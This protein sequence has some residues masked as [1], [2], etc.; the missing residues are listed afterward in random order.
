MALAA[1]A[2]P[3][4]ATTFVPMS[5]A[6]LVAQAALVVEARV[7]SA[8]P[9]PV[10]GRPAT[11]YAVEVLRTLK[12]A[13]PT[14]PLTV[15]V[16]GGRGSDG[17]VYRV[18]G[19][20]V[21]VPGERTILFL[22]E[23]GDGTLGILQL[24]LGVFHEE[25]RDGRPLA[26]RDLS[27][28]RPVALDGRAAEAEPRGRARDFGAFADWLAARGS[29]E[30]GP[31]RYLVEVAPGE[32][33]RLSPRY[34]LLES[35]GRPFRWFDGGGSWFAHEAGQAG[36]PGGGFAEFQAALAAWNAD[37]GSALGLAYGG[38]TSRSSGFQATDGTS[39]ILFDD[40]N[41]EITG[42]FGCGSG[43]VLAIGGFSRIS[44]TGVHGGE[45]FWAIDE[46]EIV[47]QDGAGCFFA[48]NGGKNGEVV[49]THELGHALG[50]GHSCG[51]GASPSCGDP[52]LNDAIMR[53]YAHGDGRGA[54]LGADDQRAVA[55]LYGSGPAPEPPP[56]PPPPPPP[57]PPPPPP[58]P[59]P[60]PPPPPPP[61]PPPPPP[62]P[63]PGLPPA[64]ADL[65]GSA[66]S[67]TAATLTW[68]DRSGGTAST[69]VEVRTGAAFQQAR[70]LPPGTTATTFDRLEPGTRYLF[71]VRARNA[72]GFSAYSNQVA[73]TPEEPEPEEPPPAAPGTL[74]AA[75]VACDAGR[76]AGLLDRLALAAPASG[77]G[78]G[79][80]L[81]LTGS[82]DFA[83][84][85]YGVEP[86][87]GLE[88]HLAFSTNPEETTLLRNPERPQ[89]ASVSLTRNHLASDLVAP[90]DTGELRLTVDPGLNPGAS[91]A[92]GLLAIDNLAGSA[93]GATSAR[94]GRG[95]SALV[96][97]CH[98]G[99]S[100]DDV[101]LFRVLAKIVRARVEGAKSYEVAI[102]RAPAPG[103]YRL[104]VYPQRGNGAPLGRLA[105]EVRVERDARGALAGGTLAIL[106][107]CGAGE[108]A[109]CSTVTAYSEL[110]LRPPA[111][112]GGAA[113]DL[114]AVF[115]P[116]GAAANGEVAV[117][118]RALLAGSTWERP[119]GGAE[120][121][122]ARAGGAPGQQPA[123]LAAAD[124]R[125]D[126]ERLAGF[127]ER[128]GLE[129]PP[130]AAPGV[131]LS[132]TRTGD[133]AG[134]AYR[135]DAPGA[136]AGQP[137]RHLAFSTNPEETTL[138]RNPARPQLL[139]VSL[140][141][142]LL[143]SDL[144]PAEADGLL[145]VLLDPTLA[146]GGGPSSGLLAIDNLAG[147]GGGATDAK[148]GRGLAALAGPCHGKLSE[149][150]VHLFR[151]LA[152]L[153]R[154]RTEG[155][156]ALRLAIFRGRAPNLFR[157]D[158][159]PQPPGG[160][161]TGWG[162]LAAELEVDFGPGDELRSATLRLLPRCAAGGPAECTDIARATELFLVRPSAGGSS[163]PSGGPRVSSTALAAG[164]GAT[165][166]VDFTALLAGTAWRKPL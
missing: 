129:A 11:D 5:D 34:T 96:E 25:V 45:T 47:T 89:L 50:L 99:F 41:G 18:W 59:P 23:R 126:A 84:L 54:R 69:H 3:S 121:L 51:D 128:L 118:W 1:A 42:S 91:S 16:P 116:S 147:P 8:R 83:G 113:A 32:P 38:T 153:V 85:A 55:Y 109:G 149:R 160:A 151:V 64:P 145:R 140:S 4:G 62:P 156:T 44:G 115:S 155:A 30:D 75:E 46:G 161:A 10:A 117:D 98:G 152:K 162:R 78:T 100:A 65:A 123:P 87:G 119:P 56:P 106:G 163:V 37:P 157:I 154:A 94:P 24:L 28:A 67:A 22:G 43:G 82:G 146:P 29:G 86:A 14:G 159:Y 138:L 61:E 17:A 66:P 141:R 139:A 76:L 73:V 111:A 81:S 90:G 166:A 120:E 131:N 53:A 110:L 80:N 137:A 72:A 103:S 21:L 58:P 114:K 52:E 107:R 132:Y 158:A 101:H 26:L 15:R 2:A 7:L 135:G 105:A 74:T 134:I 108:G 143:N 63:G 165:S 130:A 104:D 33:P 125:C 164:S 68:T 48:G 31:G 35:G 112:G 27:E 79:V 136:G 20:P 127:L 71:R 6:D 77:R 148:P 95:L 13:P 150:D 93:E 142:N 19:A 102:Y 70:V 144:V 97:P 133:F 57:E 12:G 92:A 124:V 49:F 88:R 60:G 40:P 9:A 39:A 36:M 122:E